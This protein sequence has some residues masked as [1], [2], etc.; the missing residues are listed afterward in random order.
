MLRRSMAHLGLSQRLP[1][2]YSLMPSRRHNWQTGSRCLAI[3]PNR[4]LEI[5]I[6][7]P[8][9]K[10]KSEISK[11]ANV[12]FIRISNLFRISKFEFRIYTLRFLGGRQPL[13][14]NGVTSSM[15][16]M[17]KP[18]ACRAVIADSRPEPGPL[19]RTSISFNP[20][21]VARSA[22]VSAARWAANGVLLRLPLKPTV[23][24]EAKQRV[25]P[26]VSVM[27]TM[28]LLKVALMWATPRLTLRRA[29]RFLL[30]ATAG[31]SQT[32]L[33]GAYPKTGT[34]TSKTRSQSPFWDRLLP[35][36][37]LNRA[38]P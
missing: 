32:P 21:L 37:A 23:P 13:C 11:P 24:A 5:R 33:L 2:R 10:S 36:Q 17:D 18:A 34:G 26:L 27:V 35:G 16:L 19:T 29:L 22:A 9:T 31:C 4:K 30:L 1:F 15:A 38:I 14:G 8:E 28:V 6:S 20:N 7:K 3:V 25:S 12:V